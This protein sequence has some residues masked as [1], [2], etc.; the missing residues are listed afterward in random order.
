MASAT[1]AGPPGDCCF[2]TVRHEGQPRGTIEKIA[3]VE[4]YVARPTGGESDKIILF[5]A[6]VYGALYANS[7]LLMDYWADNGELRV[8]DLTRRGRG[9]RRC[10]K[11]FLVLGLDYFER[12]S[13]AYHKDQEGWDRQGWIKQKQDRAAVLLPPWIE[14]VRARYELTGL[15]V[16]YCFGAPYV[17]DYIK[18]DWVLAGAFA[19]PAFLNEDH[20]KGVKQ[21]DRTFPVESRRRAEDIL[22]EQKAKYYIQVFSGVEHGFALR[23]D[24][25]VP[26]QRWAKEESARGILNWFKHFCD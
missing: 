22:V 13:F 23:G 19:H 12:D 1:L 8:A 6:D 16:G 9:L 18:T 15:G 17:M 2:K 14:A 10:P 7:Q 26:I 25:S 20:F 4:T 24:M 3:D 5:F 11:G 21:V